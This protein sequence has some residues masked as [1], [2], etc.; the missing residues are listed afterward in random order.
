MEEIFTQSEEVQD[1]FY[2]QANTH[3]WDMCFDD[4]DNTVYFPN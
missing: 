2:M 1:L 3:G 4:R